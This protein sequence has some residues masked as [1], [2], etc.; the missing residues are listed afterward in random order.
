M[1]DAPAETT[2]T[3]DVGGTFEQARQAR[4]WVRDKVVGNSWGWLLPLGLAPVCF[5]A[6]AFIP[7]DTIV[8]AGPVSV[9]AVVLIGSV[10]EQLYAGL[11]R[12][13]MPWS[14]TGPAIALALLW[15]LCIA[16]LAIGL[17]APLSFRLYDA[18]RLHVSSGIHDAPHGAAAI[19]TSWEFAVAYFWQFCDSLPTLKVTDTIGWKQP[20]QHGT[21]MG[22]L[23]VSFR[24]LVLVPLVASLVGIWSGRQDALSTPGPPVNDADALKL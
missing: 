1:A 13:R 22:L 4:R 24:G 5:F 20:L 2:E 16:L 17:F 3:K 6:L 7:M 15:T 10:F 18:G 19:R 23:L 9:V 14:R 8:T 21:R 12:G 11:W